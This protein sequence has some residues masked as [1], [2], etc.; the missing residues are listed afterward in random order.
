MSINWSAVIAFIKG[1][2]QQLQGGGN[3]PAP[4]P[5]PAPQPQPPSPAPVV[6]PVVNPPS[7]SPVEP[8]APAPAAPA[9]PLDKMTAEIMKNEG[10]FVD[11]PSD[12]GG[13]TK[14]GISLNFAKGHPAFFDL[15]G[16]GEVTVDDIKALTPAK[17]AE[18]YVD[19]FYQPARLDQLPNVSN[20]VM[21][22]FDCAVNMGVNVE[23]GE[24]E[25]VKILQHALGLAADGEIGPKTLSAVNA[26]IAAHGAVALNNA[27]VDARKTFYAQV[28]AAHP[29]DTKFLKGWD[30]RADKYRA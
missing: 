24:T 22:L 23:D 1:V 19:F 13:A 8:P 4:A 12:S 11:D 14:Y 6:P 10:G 5:A 26:Y 16:D 17:A 15:N 7:P 29:V 20:L 27:V 2:I 9:W 21:Q 3:P 25:A 18:A 28:V 30:T